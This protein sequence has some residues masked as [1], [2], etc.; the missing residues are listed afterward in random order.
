MGMKMM[1]VKRKLSRKRSVSPA[2]EGRRLSPG[3]Q[4]DLSRPS[5]RVSRR[6]SN[7]FPGLPAITEYLE[8]IKTNQSSKAPNSSFLEEGE[9]F[10]TPPL[11]CGVLGGLT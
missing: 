6:C 2:V 11:G 9:G 8:G 10:Y 5:N 1:W 3:S 7:I 4:L